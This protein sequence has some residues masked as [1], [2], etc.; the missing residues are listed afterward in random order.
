MKGHLRAAV[1]K[2]YPQAVE[3]AAGQSQ[4]PAQTFPDTCPGAQQQILDPD[5]F[6][7]RHGIA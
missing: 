5:L 3:L 4:L 6:A 1:A 2:A 7:R